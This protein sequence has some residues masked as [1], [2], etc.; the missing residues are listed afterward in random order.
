MHTSTK[1]SFVNPTL[2]DDKATSVETKPQEQEKLERN[3]AEKETGRANAAQGSNRALLALVI[4]MCL[5]SLVVLL[6]TLLMLFGKIG[7][8]CGCSADE[9]SS[10]SSKSLAMDAA[11][12][13]NI[14]NLQLGLFSIT[15]KLDAHENWGSCY[16]AH[17]GGF[18]KTAGYNNRLVLSNGLSLEVY[19]EDKE[20]RSGINFVEV[21]VVEDV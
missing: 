12:K 10:S 4:T 18:V 6:L 2:E 15:L 14:T 8:G 19:K 11:L 21:T 16:S 5:I 20:E 1:G 13:E 9:A 7:D 3:A 17:E